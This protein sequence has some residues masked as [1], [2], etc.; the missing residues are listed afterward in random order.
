[1]HILNTATDVSTET[2]STEL[3]YLQIKDIT[4]KITQV[5]SLEKDPL[6]F[7]PTTRTENYWA[8]KDHKYIINDDYKKARLLGSSITLNDLIYEPNPNGHRLF[9]RDGLCSYDNYLRGKLYYRLG[10]FKEAAESWDIK[11]DSSRKYQN[12]LFFYTG[13]CFTLSNLYSNLEN[14]E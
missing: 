5:S 9:I 2:P 4:I 14:N 11:R 1:M 3:Y 6:S 7:I 13:P 8:L 10:N 12:V